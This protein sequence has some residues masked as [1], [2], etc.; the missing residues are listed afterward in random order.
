MGTPP[1]SASHRQR[2]VHIWT[3]VERGFTF[4][5]SS[6]SRPEAPSLELPSG[7]EVSEYGPHASGI[8]PIVDLPMTFEHVSDAKSQW[9]VGSLQGYPV[10]MFPTALTSTQATVK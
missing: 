5:P 4:T 3:T 6:H 1:H 10:L 7:P 9:V 2:S 8:A